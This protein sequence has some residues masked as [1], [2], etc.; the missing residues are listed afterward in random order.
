M[1]KTYSYKVPEELISE[2][3]FGIRVEVPLRNKLYSAIVVEVSDELQVSYRLKT[4]IS[5]IDSEPIINLYQYEFW[6]WIADYYSCTIGEVMNVALPSGLKLNSET[7]IISNPSYVLNEHDLN[8]D[9]YLIA[10]AISIQNE[11]TIDQI[12]DILDKKS[13]YPLVRDLIDKG[14]ISIK[15]QLIEKYKPKKV[16]MVKLTPYYEEDRNR[17]NEAFDLIKRSTHQ[18][19]ALI[20]YV[21]LS[22]G[23]VE[24]PKS[25]IYDL[26]GVSSTVINALVKKQI[27]E[28]FNK[29]VT[30]L[31]YD[32]SV[33]ELP[34]LSP[35]QLEIVSTI[36]KYHDNDK[37]VLLHGVTGSGKTRVYMEIM[38]SV[39]EAG[40]QVLYL[41]PEIALTTQIVERLQFVFGEDVIV[42]HSRMSNNERVELWKEAMLG[43]KVIIGARSSLFLPF[44]NLGLVIVDEEHDASYKQQDPAPRYNARDAATY[45]ANKLG[46]KVILGSATPSLE[47]FNNVHHGKYV[48]CEMQERHGHVAMPHI[49]LVDLKYAYKTNRIEGY[50]SHQLIEAIKTALVNK[51]QVL[52]FQNRRG[53][54]PTTN[55]QICGWQS[56][57][58]NCDISLTYHKF[59]HELR[60]HYCGHRSPMPEECPACGNHELTEKGIGTEKI[61]AEVYKLFEDAKVARMDYD[62]VR[63]KNSYSRILES[64][65]NRSI[66]VLVGTQMI[67][68][69]LDF[70]NIGLVGVLNADSLLQFP[71]FRAGERA[72][73][74]LTQVA[75]RAGRRKKQGKVMIQTFSTKHPVLQEII[76]N[77]IDRFLARESIERQKF[78]YPPFYKMIQIQLKHKKPQ[79]VEDAAKYMALE[80][81]KTLKKRVLGPAAPGVARLKGLYLQNILIKIEKKPSMV[82]FAKKEVVRLRNN[83]SQSVGFKTVRVKIDVDPY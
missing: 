74:L 49:E 52:L 54:A 56:E 17:L 70:D 28:V 13:V 78:A 46:A 76:T 31:S 41:L 32:E 11:L 45:L 16:G 73:Q 48:L 67:T 83:L 26:T 62:T 18:T 3:K 72:F 9:E 39:I 47:S 77:N 71:D 61:E 55:C 8:D 60:C 59:F 65:A 69:G 81:S 57:C 79:T 6:A 30:R 58:P 29:E 14:V 35:K 10:E 38:T 63:S 40:K 21:S 5:I 19:N 42:F 15:E 12:K 80:L 27:F 24:V 33:G 37:I 2:I 53:F 51:E 68:K 22:R 7:R 44:S 23:G 36:N 20:G 25:S 82:K 66:D 50:F 43:R 64:F 1:P 75:G 4:I 34:M